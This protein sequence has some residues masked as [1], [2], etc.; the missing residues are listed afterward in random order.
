MGEAVAPS[1]GCYGDFIL[2]RGRWSWP[3][4]LE[5]REGELT[6]DEQQER[7]RRKAS[8]AVGNTARGRLC[9]RGFD[10]RLEEEV[11]LTQATGA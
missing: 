11:E 8:V 1:A 10:G 7:A 9:L 3:V 5:V 2:R 4:L 6:F